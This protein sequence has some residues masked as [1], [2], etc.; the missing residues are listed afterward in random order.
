MVSN[1][2]KDR[3]SLCHFSCG[4]CKSVT[5][6]CHSVC[7]EVKRRGLNEVTVVVEGD[8]HGVGVLHVSLNGSEEK[9]FCTKFVPCDFRG[10]NDYFGAEE[11]TELESPL[12]PADSC[13]VD[14]RNG[15]INY[16]CVLCLGPA[17]K[18]L[19]CVLLEKL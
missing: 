11:R 8:Q 10:T 1:I 17:A 3:K 2:E 15:N 13:E 19:C 6:I 14:K 9:R 12:S 7:T 18:L 5:I 16:E 4:L